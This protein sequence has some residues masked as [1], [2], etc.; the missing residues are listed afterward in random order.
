MLVSASIAFSDRRY[1]LEMV[2][3]KAVGLYENPH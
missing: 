2:E 3:M 1:L